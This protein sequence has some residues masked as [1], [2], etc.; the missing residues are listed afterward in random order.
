LFGANASAWHAKAGEAIAEMADPGDLLIASTD[1]SHYHPQAEANALDTRSIDCLLTQDIAAYTS[2]VADGRCLMCG[3][4]AVEAAM[5]YAKALG[6]ND[7]KLLDYRTSAEASGDF[8]AVV[9]YAAVSME[10][11]A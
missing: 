8:D 1:L 2:A 10:R 6:A 4:S 9:G 3:S 7:W 5:A 11:P